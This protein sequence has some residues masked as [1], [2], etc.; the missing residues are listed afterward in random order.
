MIGEQTWV[1][2]IVGERARD[3][4]L[5]IEAEA[6]QHL[7]QGPCSLCVKNCSEYAEEMLRA[8][9]PAR[10]VK[11]ADEEGEGDGKPKQSKPMPKKR[12]RTSA[13]AH[14]GKLVLDIYLQFDHF[15]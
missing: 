7:R 2:M 8:D 11:V 1:D 15:R 13:C 12:A 9:V 5:A 4:N 6:K 14:A 10:R 3:W